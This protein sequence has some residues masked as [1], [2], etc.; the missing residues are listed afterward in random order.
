M[1]VLSGSN[2]LVVFETDRQQL[3]C[4]VCALTCCV[5]GSLL[6][7]AHDPGLCVLDAVSLMGV[8]CSD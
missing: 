2:C 7:A 8:G 5:I 6:C 1:V 3:R 4:V